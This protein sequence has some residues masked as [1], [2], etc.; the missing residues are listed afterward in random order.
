MSRGGGEALLRYLA[1]DRKA[2]ASTR[3]QALHAA[4]FLYCHVL[5]TDIGQ[6]ENLRQL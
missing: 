6:I 5:K 2:S 3:N 1:V 4:V